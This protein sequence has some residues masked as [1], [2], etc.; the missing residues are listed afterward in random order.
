M[1]KTGP[2][3]RN[4]SAA[5]ASVNIT[6]AVG[7]LMAGYGARDKCSGAVEDEL[8][9]KVLVLDDSETRAA[10]VAA[11]L[12]ALPRALAD[13]LRGDIER[14][15]GVQASNCFVCASHTHFGP[16]VEDA[17]YLGGGL[18][19]RPDAE[20]LEVLVRKVGGAAEMAAG[21]LAPARVG[22]GS[23]T[24][25]HLAYNRRTL[26]ADGKVEMSWTLP[27]PEAGL[28]FGPKDPQ[29]GVVK[30]ESKSG[31]PIAVLLNFA[32]HAVCG[33]V[34]F[35]AISADYPGHAVRIVEERRSGKC[36]FLPG[37][38]GNIVPLERGG[39]SR[40][41]IGEALGAAALSIL[42]FIPTHSTARLRAA[43]VPFDLPLK[44]LPSLAE[45]NEQVESLRQKARAAP[46]GKAVF[47][48]SELLRARHLRHLAER[49][50]GRESYRAETTALAIGD[51]VLVGL[52]GEVLC[53][54][55][56]AIKSAF[57]ADSCFVASLVNDCPGYIPND[58]AYEQGGYEPE[59]TPFARGSEGAI[60]AAG[61]EAA[62]AAL[63]R[64]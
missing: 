13:R 14:R 11:D 38:G 33:G 7:C 1:R 55:G 50:G 43:T 47:D 57:S 26:R 4:L 45:A 42:D 30:I 25:G 5:A 18:D 34:D 39:R 53:E 44:K 20:W 21:R 24:A 2:E 16:V 8:W 3:R 59:W 29:V 36:L 37:A 27:P 28:A 6:P 23:A 41:R 48:P 49:F 63:G 17:Y 58:L 62:R 46:D 52:P 9:A 61:V 12:I 60:V 40:R 32:C 51:A 35:Y 64:W 56:M 54:M 15:A 31:E 19:G 10:I 22:A